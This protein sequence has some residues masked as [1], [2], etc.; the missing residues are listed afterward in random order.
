MPRRKYTYP[1]KKPPH[2]NNQPQDEPVP[3]SLTPQ[4]S[5]LRGSAHDMGPLSS[6]LEGLKLSG[7]GVWGGR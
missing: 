7:S 3:S 5:F 6:T 4:G 1:D 2:K